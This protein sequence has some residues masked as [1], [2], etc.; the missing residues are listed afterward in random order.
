MT[1]SHNFIVTSMMMMIII[2]FY[3]SR[4]IGCNDNKTFYFRE[5]IRPIE[6]ACLCKQ[7]LY[8]VMSL[9]SKKGSKI[10][11]LLSILLSVILSIVCEASLC[12]NFEYADSDM[13]LYKP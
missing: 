1:H 6:I 10:G 3:R 8:I 2:I 5:T 11:S 12:S 13:Q 9:S 4:V 7:Y